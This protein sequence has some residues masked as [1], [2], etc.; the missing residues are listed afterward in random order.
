M[1]GNKNFIK[2]CLK[3]T[4]DTKREIREKPSKSMK[5]PY[6]IF[7]MILPAHF[8]GVGKISEF[9]I[10]AKIGSKN[11]FHLS[12]WRGGTVNTGSRKLIFFLQLMTFQE[13]P[14]KRF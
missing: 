9:A 11:T 4:L 2:H 8:Q 12:G 6:N 3:S 14:L 13:V 10:F 5:G 1:D 7:F